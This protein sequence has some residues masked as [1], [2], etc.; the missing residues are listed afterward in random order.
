MK[1][2]KVFVVKAKDVKPGLFLNEF[3][4]VKESKIIWREKN[5]PTKTLVMGITE[6][7]PAIKATMHRHHTE[8]IYYILEGEGCVEVEGETIGFK[9]GDTVFLLENVKHRP[10]NT[11]ANNPLKFVYACGVNL[12]TYKDSWGETFPEES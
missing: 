3:P 4:G 7:P 2:Q 12:E 6:V 8:E 10:I 1:E 5:I 11:D 9:K